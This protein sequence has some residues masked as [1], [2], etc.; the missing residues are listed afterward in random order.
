M[1][2]QSPLDRLRDRFEF[3][4]E[5]PGYLAVIV[6]F[7]LLLAFAP[8]AGCSFSADADASVPPGATEA[9]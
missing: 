4:A 8:K 9:R 6:L 7:L 1:N 3:V 5:E 2:S